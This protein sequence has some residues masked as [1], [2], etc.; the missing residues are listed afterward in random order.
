MQPTNTFLEEKWNENQY[1]E[2]TVEGDHEGTE[3]PNWGFS[4][5]QVTS[6][7]KGEGGKKKTCN[8]KGW[9]CNYIQCSI[10]HLRGGEVHQSLE[11]FGHHQ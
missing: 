1:C 5:Y 2:W 4:C 3:H 6:Q 8:V 7:S 11:Y 10:D 9:R